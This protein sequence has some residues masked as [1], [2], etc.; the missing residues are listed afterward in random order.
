MSVVIADRFRVKSFV[1]KTALLCCSE[2]CVNITL[3]LLNFS[4]EFKLEADKYHY[5]T[6][7]YNVLV[8]RCRHTDIYVIVT[9]CIMIGIVRF[10]YFTLSNEQRCNCEEQL[11]L[12]HPFPL[13]L[14]IC[15][16]VTNSL[17]F[18]L[19]VCIRVYV[20]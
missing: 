17:F 18:H 11:L 14:S 7:K 20:C 3:Q 13:C 9:K 8:N 2:A 1:H 10:V 16:S 19:C 4:N 5:I 15:V 12:T 6:L